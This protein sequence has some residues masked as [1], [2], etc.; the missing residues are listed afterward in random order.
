MTTIHIQPFTSVLFTQVFPHPHPTPTLS[1]DTRYPQAL[2]HCEYLIKKNG[3][4]GRDAWAFRR[5][6]LSAAAGLGALALALLWPTGFFGP[7]SLRVRSLFIKHTRTGNPLVDSV[8]EHQPTSGDAYW[9]DPDKRSGRG[10]RQT[11]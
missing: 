7:L 9:C 6:Y 1:A 3:T 2:Y 10:A 11:G 4:T 8:A 5:S